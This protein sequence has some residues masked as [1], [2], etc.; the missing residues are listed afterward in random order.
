M[1]ITV[2]L[3]FYLFR[4]LFFPHSLE[5]YANYFCGWMAKLWQKALLA[6]KALFV[7]SGLNH[8]ME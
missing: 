1:N 4:I 3:H 5:I 2:L 8:G 6:R 7:C